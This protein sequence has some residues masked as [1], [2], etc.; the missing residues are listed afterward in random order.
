MSANVIHVVTKSK[1]RMTRTTKVGRQEVVTVRI[2]REERK[3]LDEIADEHGLSVSDVVRM[4][5][6]RVTK[7]GVPLFESGK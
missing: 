2:T 1:V 6:R 4:C 7:D 3:T 5:I